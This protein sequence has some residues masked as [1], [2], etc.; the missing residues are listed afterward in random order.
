MAKKAPQVDIRK[1]KDDVAEHLKK[2]RWE[3]AAEVL[4]Q[5]VAAEPKD[6]AQR[7]KLGD[8]YRRMDRP[9]LAIQAYQHVAR[10]FGDEGQLIKAIG[11]VKIILEID[12]RNA[13]AQKQLAAMNERRIGKVSLV[14]A[15]PRKG[16]PPGADRRTGAIELGGLPGAPTDQGASMGIELDDPLGASTDPGASMEIELPAGAEDEPL[17]LDDGRSIKPPASR[18]PAARPPPD[19]SGIG[20]AELGRG[21][22]EPPISRGA[23]RRRALAPPLPLMDDPELDPDLPPEQPQTLPDDAILTPEPEDL[24]AA[25]HDEEVIP[26][27]EFGRQ[28][29]PIA[30]LLSSSAE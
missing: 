24:A 19:V 20:E 14:R 5:L 25:P 26:S 12:P 2:S 30:D 23:A 10:F 1:L 16:P 9:Q 27:E 21:G 29:G 22:E 3:K 28:G 18:S 13:E 4:E 6:M 15:E 7:L 8:T 11:A 17:E